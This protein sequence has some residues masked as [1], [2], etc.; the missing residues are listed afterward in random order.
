MYS[1][2]IVDDNVRWAVILGEM[3]SRQDEFYLI[4]SA[5]NG[6]DAMETI[7]AERPDIILLDIVL[8]EFDGVYITQYVRSALEG[9]EPIL[10]ILSGLGSD[11][12][13]HTLNGLGVDYYSMKPIPAELV[14]QN[15]QRITRKRQSWVEWDGMQY[16][17]VEEYAEK[18]AVKQTSIQLGLTPSRISTQYVIEAIK[19]CM[20]T[21]ENYGLLTKVIYPEIAKKHDATPASVER[22][23][24]SAVSQV[25]K[26]NTLLS[27]KIFAHLASEKITNSEFLSLVTEHVMGNEAWQQ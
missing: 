5:Q 18:D 19:M 8:P 16:P 12:M 7:Q 9:Y 27:Q 23:I 1:V 6:Y 20:E 24:R 11:E 10:Y 21:P 17:G 15:I 14:I 26:R 13:V 22:N 4:G 25:K 2:F 3:I